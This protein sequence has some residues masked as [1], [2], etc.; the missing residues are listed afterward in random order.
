MEKEQYLVSICIPTYNRAPYLKKC[1][2]SLVCQPEFQ[3]GLVEIV[4]SDNA[5]TDDTEK[6][7]EAYSTAYPNFHY[8]KNEVNILDQNFPLAILRGKGLL[9]KLN[10]DS[11]VFYPGSLNFLC[12]I[13]QKYQNERPI[14]FFNN[15]HLSGTDANSIVEER[16]AESALYKISYQVTWIGAFAI[17]DTDCGHLK[18]TFQDCQTHLWQVC[19]YC[20]LWE[21]SQKTVII[22]TPF[23]DV[24]DVKKKD[25][26]YG[27][28]LVFFEYYPNII[29]RLVNESIISQE[30][31][32]YLEKDLLLRFGV[33]TLA[34][35]K[36]QRA[37]RIYSDEEDLEKL[38]FSKYAGKDYFLD[39]KNKYKRAKFKK[40]IRKIP[41]VGTL[42]ARLR[43][44]F[45]K[46]RVI[47]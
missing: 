6:V 32:D 38:I 34:S 8:Y 46:K 26:S 37:S 4:V 22:D 27:I 36:I 13:A 9:R 20:R 41:V 39:F 12:E 33:D 14:L 2:D 18:E 23:L 7:A 11:S 35:W 17:W 31:L 3:Q 25:V 5:S 29:K 16:T 15:G 47:G 42:L 21:R 44:L 43:D 45:V 10:N 28:F 1:L 30:C 19:E 40:R 24:Q